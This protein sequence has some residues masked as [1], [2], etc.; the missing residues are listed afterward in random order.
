METFILVMFILH[1]VSA[2]LNLAAL[3]LGTGSGGAGLYFA[4][5]VGMSVWAGLLLWG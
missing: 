1:C 4:G 5:N 3:T 2:V